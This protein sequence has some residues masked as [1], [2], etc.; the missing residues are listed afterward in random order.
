MPQAAT[1]EDACLSLPLVSTVG[2]AL[3][4]VQH[5]SSSAISLQEAHTSLQRLSQAQSQQ[6]LVDPESSHSLAVMMDGLCGFGSAHALGSG[7]LGL[8]A[9][10]SEAALAACNLKWIAGDL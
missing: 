7:D 5:L 1:Q 6:Q 2:E 9:E 4:Q 10:G 8:A 3:D